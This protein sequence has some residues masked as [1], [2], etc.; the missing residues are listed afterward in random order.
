[1]SWPLVYPEYEALKG[2]EQADKCHMDGVS[3]WQGNPPCETHAV[4]QSE[5][6]EDWN[7]Y[8][9]HALRAGMQNP[10]SM[11]YQLTR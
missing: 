11:P 10:K 2:M 7:S 4:W 6:V 3:V 1:M 5:N 8:K 9:I